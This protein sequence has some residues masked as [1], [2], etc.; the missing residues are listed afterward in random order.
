MTKKSLNGA[1]P[2]KF[3]VWSWIGKE[4]TKPDWK[5]YYNN[6]LIL[7]YIDARDVMDHLDEVV[8]PENREKKYESINGKLYCWVWINRQFKNESW[9]A[10]IRK[11]WIWKRDVWEK[12]K[13]SAD[14]GEAS[15]AFKR[16]SVCRG[17]GRFLYSIPRI[18]LSKD[19]V[20]AHQYDLTAFVKEKF[21]TELTEWG[22]KQKEKIELLEQSKYSD[23]ELIAWEE[24]PKTMDELVDT[25]DRQE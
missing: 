16:A 9:N 7:A 19:E 23:D 21:K 8:W 2:I 3:R 4:E 6:Y 11:E 17:I 18:T 12:S 13:I 10:I 5:K 22:K 20:G 14:K 1:L 15:D 25:S 24:T